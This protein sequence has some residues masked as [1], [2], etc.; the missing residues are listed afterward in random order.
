MA[1][2]SFVFIIKISYINMSVNVLKNNLFEFTKS[3]GEINNR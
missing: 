2:H 1:T 3:V